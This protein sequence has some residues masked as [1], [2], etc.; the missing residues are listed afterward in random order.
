MSAQQSHARGGMWDAEPQG[1]RAV[2]RP[3]A[4]PTIRCHVSY[5]TCQSPAAMRGGGDGENSQAKKVTA[6]RRKRR[7]AES[8]SSREELSPLRDLRKVINAERRRTG[9]RKQEA[10]SRKHFHGGCEL[11]VLEVVQD[12]SLVN[13]LRARLVGLTTGRP[14]RVFVVVV[15]CLDLVVL[16][17]ETDQQSVDKEVVLTGLRH[18][19]LALFVAEVFLKLAALR[20]HY[21]SDGWNLLDLAVTSVSILGAVSERYLVVPLN[22]PVLAVLRVVH[23]VRLLSEA[24]GVRKLLHA[25]I[26]SLPALFNIGLLLFIVTFTS[27]VFGMLTFGQVKRGGALDDVLNFETFGGSVACVLL[28]SSSASWGGLLA[29]LMATPPHCDP[30]TEN[31][32]AAVSGDCGH[33]AVAVVF[34]V[35]H[36]GFTLLLAVHLYIAVV[37]ETFESEDAEPLSDAHFHKF[38]D[39]WKKFDPE[40]SQFIPYRWVLLPTTGGSYFLLQV[41][42]TSYYRWVLLPTTGGSYF[43]LQ[44]GSTS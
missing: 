40:A 29:P 9:S 4:P 32:G 8:Q 5:T 27:S 42:P 44:V 18:A 13:R 6:G 41:G 37:L 10:G 24:G 31:P 36:I 35:A 23:V 43:L 26:L 19:F 28:V 30:D 17:L 3:Q 15:V 34:F 11:I 20:Q 22:A 33:P 1:P 16:M 39:T 25:F 7:G 38:D 21:F 12:Y 14:F 2:W